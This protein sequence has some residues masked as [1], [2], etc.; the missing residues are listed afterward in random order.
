MSPRSC[1]R[2]QIVEAG[3]GA[4]SKSRFSKLWARET[5]WP[6]HSSRLH[7]AIQPLYNRATPRVFLQD[8]SAPRPQAASKWIGKN[9]RYCNHGAAASHRP[10]ALNC[11]SAER[12]DLSI[13]PA[14]FPVKPLSPPGLCVPYNGRGG[15]IAAIPR[16]RRNRRGKPYRWADPIEAAGLRSTCVVFAAAPLD[17]NPTNNR[18]RDL[19][20]TPANVAPPALGCGAASGRPFGMARGGSEQQ[21]APQPLGDDGRLRL[22]LWPYTDHSVLIRYNVSMPHRLR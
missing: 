1:T 22:D 15:D 2:Q 6:D 8:Q 19:R 5:P 7:P 20:I 4:P 9:L 13:T 18:L 10:R 16:S 17:G 3:G 21:V 14:P 12:V 11:G